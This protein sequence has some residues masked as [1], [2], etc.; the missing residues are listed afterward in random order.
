MTTVT[1]PD[2]QLVAEF[3]VVY[4]I[5]CGFLIYGPCFI[6]QYFPRDAATL[7]RVSNAS[8]F[9]VKMTSASLLRLSKANLSSPS[10]VYYQ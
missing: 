4:Y 6:H 7:G 8:V 10:T 3:L 9:N 1:M 2:K 5:F